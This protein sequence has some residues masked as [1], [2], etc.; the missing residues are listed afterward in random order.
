MHATEGAHLVK[1]VVL[2]APEG[3]VAGHSFLAKRVLPQNPGAEECW[4]FL[5]APSYFE[6]VSS[7]NCWF[8]ATR[9]AGGMATYEE[10]HR[11]E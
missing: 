9:M 6:F 5:Q 10:P 11:P 7:R 1:L 2:A 8:V 3:S 4:Q